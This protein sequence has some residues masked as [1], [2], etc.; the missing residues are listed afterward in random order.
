MQIS[1]IIKKIEWNTRDRPDW[2]TTRDNQYISQIKIAK[3]K[4][5]LK[6]KLRFQIWVI[7]QEL[8]EFNDK[9]V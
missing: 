2:L 3:L 1:F 8:Y 5:N 6:V 4:V 7:L 9:N